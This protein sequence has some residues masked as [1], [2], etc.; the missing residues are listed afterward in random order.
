MV[1]GDNDVVCVGSPGVANVPLR[2]GMLMT[3]GGYAHVG[4]GGI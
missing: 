1:F 4:A 2:W 3:E